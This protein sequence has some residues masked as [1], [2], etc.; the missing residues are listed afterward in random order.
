MRFLLDT[1]VLRL[2]RRDRR[3][4]PQL[5]RWLELQLIPEFSKRTLPVDAAIARRTAPL[6]V[7]DPMPADDAYIAATA[8][9]H[10][11]VLVTHNL[12]DFVRTGVRTFDPR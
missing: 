4:G 10:D 11:L 5:R 8:L 9:V 6:H 3:Q 2:E 1:G 7:P 12:R